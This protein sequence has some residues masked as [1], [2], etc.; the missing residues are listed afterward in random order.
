MTGVCLAN[1]ILAFMFVKESRNNKDQREFQLTRTLKV[2]AF[3]LRNILSE[4][5]EKRVIL[6]DLLFNRVMT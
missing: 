4:T 5:S 3:S 2:S 1:I 6:L